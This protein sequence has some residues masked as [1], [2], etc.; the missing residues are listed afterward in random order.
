ML[1]Y[2]N[3]LLVTGRS[4]VQPGLFSTRKGS[5]Q[6]N[7]TSSS[8]ISSAIDESYSTSLIN[9]DTRNR[10]NLR[11]QLDQ[12]SIDEELAEINRSTNS[13]SGDD[14]FENDHGQQT[15]S[16][17]DRLS[18]VLPYMGVDNDDC[19]LSPVVHYVGN[20]SE[21]NYSETDSLDHEQPTTSYTSLVDFAAD[22]CVPEAHNPKGTRTIT[23]STT[24][25]KAS[26]LGTDP[27]R[28]QAKAGD[29]S[30]VAEFYN[31]SRLH[32]LSTW[33]AEFRSYVNNL[34]CQGTVNFPGR[35]V[36]RNMSRGT[37]V[38]EGLLDING[39]PQRVVMHIDMDSFFVSVGLRNRPDLIGMFLLF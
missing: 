38:N 6:S 37:E 31:N 22:K 30:F 14:L 11:T 3:Y 33:G 10:E 28:A 13:A 21:Y 32:Y 19:A 7:K 17:D 27:Y 39:K 25:A 34:Q 36:L 35:E 29:P 2:E 26:S 9:E 24:M 18:P 16:D 5:F 4:K 20:D 12:S 23:E 1:P 15:T 8:S